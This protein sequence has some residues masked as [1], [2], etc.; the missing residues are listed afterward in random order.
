[1]LHFDCDYMRGCHSEILEKLACTNLE[2]HPGYG[3]DEYTAKAKELILNACGLE[4]ADIYLLVGGTQTNAVILDCLVGSWQGIIC[5]DTGHINVHEAGAVEAKG[6]KVISLPSKD[7]KITADD[8][9]K[10]LKDFY[11][12]NSWEHMVQP[13]GLYVTYPTEL[14]TLYTV[15]ELKALKKV[16]EEYD[17]LFYIDGARLLY[18]LAADPSVTLPDIAGIADA[19]YIGGTKCGTLFGEAVVV[20]DRR[21]TPRFFSRIKH[22][23][24]LLAKGRISGVQF[25]ALFEN[26]LWHRVG[27]NA[28]DTARKLR[29]GLLEKGYKMLVDSPTNQQFFIMPNDVVAE[30]RKK[31]SFEN[32]GT[33]GE[34]ETQVRFVTDWA[35][36]DKEVD[37]FLAMVPKR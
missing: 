34:T 10:Y 31:A 21:L 25:M 29:N 23:G 32:W 15:A 28:V 24:A 4:D 19:F 11:N 5:A 18:G 22:Q 6:H 16:C 33:P 36:T 26:D 12:D 3:R 8:V 30:L 2:Q 17:L 20:P 35:T 27:V 37:E 14:G 9:R 13:G 7:G 1:M